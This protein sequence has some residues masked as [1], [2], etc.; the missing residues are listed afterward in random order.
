MAVELADN[1]SDG[2]KVWLE[3]QRTIYS[4]NVTENKALEA[5]GDRNLGYVRL[6]GR[7]L[8]GVT[9]EEPIVSF[10]SHYTHQPLL[11]GRAE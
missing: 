1:M 5:D 11:R 10:P 7:R 9:L 6:V 3:W 2:G 4:D 8:G